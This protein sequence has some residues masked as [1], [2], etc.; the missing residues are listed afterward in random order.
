MDLARPWRVLELG[1]AGGVP[2]AQLADRGV[3]VLAVDADLSL[4]P[5]PGAGLLGAPGSTWPISNSRWGSCRLAGSTARKRIAE[6]AWLA[7]Q[8]SWVSGVSAS[9]GRCGIQLTGL[10]PGP[11]TLVRLGQGWWP[12]WT[13]GQHRDV[14]YREAAYS[15]CAEAGKPKI[16][17]ITSAPWVS[18]GR[19]SCR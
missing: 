10:G 13:V 11:G 3:D 5:W 18:A 19:S 9:S 6:L 7:T 2:T 12:G 4:S 16:V 1:C 15:A 8:D 14:G 17:S